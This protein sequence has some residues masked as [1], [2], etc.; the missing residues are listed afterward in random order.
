M[1]RCFISFDYD[2]DKI[3]KDFIIGQSKNEDSPFSI[4][5]WSIKDPSYDWKEKARYRIRSSNIV[6]ILCG[7]HTSSASGISI[8]LGIAQ[9]E[10]VP[11]FLLEGYADGN[12]QR[13]SNAKD[14]DKMYKWTWNNLKIL[15]DGGR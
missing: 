2:H 14:I 9:E 8:E 12:C 7:K 13:P 10:N 6:I 5:D 11:Y 4:E 15:I 3:L 1:K